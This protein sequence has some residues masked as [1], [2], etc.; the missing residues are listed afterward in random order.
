[1]IQ[2][3]EHA[4]EGRNPIHLDLFAQDLNTEIERVVGLGAT[5]LAQHEGYGTV[6]ATLA[7]PD[8]YVF[9]L[10]AHPE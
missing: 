3:V 1:M 9:D 6:W 4:S 2:R 8:G 5:R 7:D 10:V